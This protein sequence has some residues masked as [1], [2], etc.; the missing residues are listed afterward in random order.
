MSP[1][2]WT[3][4]QNR[5]CRTNLSLPRVDMSRARLGGGARACIT[6]TSTNDDMYTLAQTCVHGMPFM[7]QSLSACGSGPST[8]RTRCTI[9]HLSLRGRIEM[10][11][12]K[13]V[14]SPCR[15]RRS[16]K[17]YAASIGFWPDQTWTSIVDTASRASIAQMMGEL[18][19]GNRPEKG[20]DP[21]MTEGWDM[22]LSARGRKAQTMD[23]H[24]T[25][26]AGAGSR[27]AVVFVGF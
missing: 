2:L 14:S 27:V 9:G 12:S 13:L 3:W 17:T 20:Y 26:C 25:C 6:A 1:A 23:G 18:R 11:R 21:S 4:S 24:S 5:S 8:N 15:R 7:P 16:R 10:V 19:A 22:A